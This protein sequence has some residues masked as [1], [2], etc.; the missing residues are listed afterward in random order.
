MTQKLSII[1][2][3]YNEG[4][5]VW[6]AFDAIEKVC[7]SQL[8]GWDFEIVFVDDGSRDD[9]F[10]QL[11][12]LCE[13]HDKAKAIRL[14]GN[15]GS[16]LAIRAGL[17]YADGDAACFIPCDLQEP[18]EII[19]ALLQELTESTPVVL[20]VRKSRQDPWISRL[21]SRVFFVLAR[22]LIGKNVPPTGIGTFMLGSPALKAMRLYKERN[23]TLGG[24]VTNM[25]FRCVHVPY[26]RQLR[27]T[28][29]SKWTL[30]KRL[31]LFTNYFV[32]YS[33][34]PIR[35]MSLLGISM[36]LIGFAWTIVVVVNWLFFSSPPPGWTSLF[37]AVLVLS[38]IQM[39]MTGVI[40][41]YLWRTLDEVRARPKYIIDRVV[42]EKDNSPENAESDCIRD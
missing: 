7:R 40:G 10:L 8:P 37:V 24:L 5:T 26:D 42:N 1:V 9:S 12:Q 4:A 30:A 33:Y 34:A 27:Q 25:G 21:Q 16:H 36:A 6:T 17:E 20:A 22:L 11:E 38:G 2:P 32:A 39:A 3:V 19:P 15:C 41:E 31:E 28:G 14:V 35:L 23:L 18:P 29:G 13:K